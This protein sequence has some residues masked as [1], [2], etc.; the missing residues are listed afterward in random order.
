[1]DFN[2]GVNSGDGNSMYEIA[3]MYAQMALRNM[4][5]NPDEIRQN[6][7][8]GLDTGSTKFAEEVEILGSLFYQLKTKGNFTVDQI[9]PLIN[10]KIDELKVSRDYVDYYTEYDAHEEDTK[11]HAQLYND[12][13]HRLPHQ[14]SF[15]KMTRVMALSDIFDKYASPTAQKATKAHII[16]LLK[17]G[18]DFIKSTIQNDISQDAFEQIMRT[19]DSI[20]N[21]INKIKASSISLNNDAEKHYVVWAKELS[22]KQLSNLIKVGEHLKNNYETVNVQP[23]IIEY[24]VIYKTIKTP[25]F[26]LVNFIFNMGKEAGILTHD[27]ILRSV[28][29][30]SPLLP[31]PGQSPITGLPTTN[32][33]YVRKPDDDEEDDDDNP[34]ID[35][36]DD[37]DNG[38]DDG[39]EVKEEE[40]D[41]GE[42]KEGDGAW[43]DPKFKT[44]TKRAQAFFFGN[45]KQIE[46]DV[47]G[48]NSQSNQEEKD[49]QLNDVLIQEYDK[50]RDS[51]GEMIAKEIT[52]YFRTSRGYNIDPFL[53][54]LR[55]KK[56]LLK[57]KGKRKILTHNKALSDFMKMYPM[58]RYL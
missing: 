5:T 3:D 50:Y 23:V 58:K 28:S 34:F 17:E 22:E 36:D 30:S 41:L 54:D 16:E 1:M 48:T 24:K 39:G 13:M 27:G 7:K 14:P 40:G 4:R 45:V 18:W 57:G 20:P 2:H 6:I 31:E 56:P 21:I 33:P 49:S 55:R 26:S 19:N 10:N 38:D 35:D 37:G 9:E 15:D 12:T 25:L 32:Q 46:Q 43:A 53:E 29:N 44:I 51:D 52:K 8:D 47:I 11:K 42:E